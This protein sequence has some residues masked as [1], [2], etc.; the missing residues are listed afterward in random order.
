MQ[1]IRQ[2]IISV[3]VAALIC[4]V[5]IGL[6]GKKGTAAAVG[7]LLAGV[8]LSIAVISPLTDFRIS[9]LTGYVDALSTDADDAVQTGT[10]AAQQ[11]LAEGIKSRSEAYIL[12][13]AAELNVQ[14][15]V[16]VRL[17]EDDPPVPCAVRIQGDVSPSAKAGLSRLIADDLGIA[18]EA[19]EW[20]A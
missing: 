9:D 13:K 17:T 20:I 7:K 16:E 12:D 3:T 8:F 10:K 5:L 19:Q 11:A 18:K 4:A 1:A 15:T 14:V 2:Y 6:L